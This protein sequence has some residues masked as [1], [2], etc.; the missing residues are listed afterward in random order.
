MGNKEEKNNAP[1]QQP[2]P[3]SY[4]EKLRREEEE[5]RALAEQRMNSGPKTGCLGMSATFL[6]AVAC[7]IFLIAGI[8]FIGYGITNALGGGDAHDVAVQIAAGC[9]ITIITVAVWIIFRKS[10][11]E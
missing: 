1:V 3:L 6:I 2:E 5:D 7:I 8:G 10:I 4:A 11:K 9:G